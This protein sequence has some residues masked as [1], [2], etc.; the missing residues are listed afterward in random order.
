MISN[1]RPLSLK[2]NCKLCVI[3]V[4]KSVLKTVNGSVETNGSEIKLRKS[5]ESVKTRNVIDNNKQ[6]LTDVQVM[7]TG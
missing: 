5:E 1:G 6:K 7:L 4:C 2:Q 3:I